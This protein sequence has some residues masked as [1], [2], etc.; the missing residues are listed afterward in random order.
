[1][2][3]KTI[4]GVRFYG[5]S[6]AEVVEAGARGGLVVVPSAP[7]LVDLASRPA[8]REAVLG[9]D[10]AIAD[11]G[12][13]VLMWR[14]LTGEKLERV[15]GLEYLKLLLEELKPESGDLKPEGSILDSSGFSSPQVS[16]FKSQDSHTAAGGV[17]WVMPT[18][19]ARDRNLTWLQANGHMTTQADCYVAPMYPSTGPLSDQSLLDWVRARQPRHIILCLGGGVQERLGYFLKQELERGTGSEERGAGNVGLPGIHCVGAAIGFLSGDQVRIPMWADY[20][21]FGWLFRCISAPRHFV[22]RYWKAVRL[23]WLLWRYGKEAPP[24]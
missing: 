12:L 7:V 20:L 5:G 24:A 3:T 9:A 8:L 6:P 13:M 21:Y 1:M 15:S 18:D 2:A 10:L 19:A 17:L 11:S 4:L 16:G 14:L 22:P 23:V